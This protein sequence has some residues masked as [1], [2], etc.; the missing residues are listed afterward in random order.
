M[1]DFKPGGTFWC[2]EEEE[3]ATMVIFGALLLAWRTTQNNRRNLGEGES[4]VTNFY[5]WKNGTRLLAQGASGPLA[6]LAA[7]CRLVERQRSRLLLTLRPWCSG[8]PV[9]RAE[10]GRHVVTLSQA[11]A[12]RS[13]SKR[14]AR[15]VS[16]AT[17]AGGGSWG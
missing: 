8:R 16:W 13:W 7:L 2:V 17:F 11:G 12:E 9:E 6:P 14:T 1:H 5:K 10:A 3:E 4:F 15:A